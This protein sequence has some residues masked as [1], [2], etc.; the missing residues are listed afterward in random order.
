MID[1]ATTYGRVSTLDG[2]TI[3]FLRG[4]L[5]FSFFFATTDGAADTLPSLSESSSAAKKLDLENIEE[6]Y[7][8]GRE[9][10]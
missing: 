5:A 8:Q 4:G 1:N 6:E 2:S 3:S 10:W 7:W 9:L